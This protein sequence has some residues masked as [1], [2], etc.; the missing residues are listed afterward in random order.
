MVSQPDRSVFNGPAFTRVIV[1]VLDALAAKSP[2]PAVVRA[3][4]SAA[5]DAINA[6]GISDDAPR[7]I[8]VCLGLSRE[9][10]ER[11]PQRQSGDER[12]PHVRLL[13]FGAAPE[14]LRTWKSFGG[15]GLHGVH[16]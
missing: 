15:R 7:I 1:G 16:P 8:Y 10:R 5:K 9:C 2:V 4:L 14:G 11:S 13:C 12:L 3:L 6:S